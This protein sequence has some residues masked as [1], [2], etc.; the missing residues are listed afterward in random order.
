MKSKSSSFALVVVDLMST[1][2][3]SAPVSARLLSSALREEG[4]DAVDRLQAVPDLVAVSAVSASAV[5]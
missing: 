4:L 5:A 3:D 2:A 1:V